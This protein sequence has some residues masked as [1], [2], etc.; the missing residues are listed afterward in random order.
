MHVAK[1]FAAHCLEALQFEAQEAPKE[2]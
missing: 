1:L 2:K